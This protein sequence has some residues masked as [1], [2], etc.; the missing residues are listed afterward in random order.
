MSKYKEKV[1]GVQYTIF[2]YNEN[3]DKKNNSLKNQKEIKPLTNKMI[4]KMA[5]PQ[6]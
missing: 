3:S 5:Q 6:I 1:E 2:I 4:F